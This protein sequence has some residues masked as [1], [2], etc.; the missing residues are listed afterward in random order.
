MGWTLEQ[1]LTEPPQPKQSYTIRDNDKCLN[2]DQDYRQALI[3]KS[4]KI[5]QLLENMSL[6]EYD[7]IYCQHIY[8]L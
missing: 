2:G 5:G 1:A 7:N 3:K 4:Y 6:L 8:K